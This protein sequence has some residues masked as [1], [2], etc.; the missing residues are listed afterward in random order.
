MMSL[1]NCSEIFL[2]RE[3]VVYLPFK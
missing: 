2:W 3:S 1:T